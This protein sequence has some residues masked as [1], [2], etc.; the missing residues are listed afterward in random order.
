MLTS[1]FAFGVPLFLLI[2][3]I[4]FSIFRK[5][6]QIP[7]LG[8]VLFTIAGFLTAF[9]LQVIQQAITEM[10]NTNQSVLED[11]Y[12]YPLYLLVIPLAIGILLIILNAYRGYK[13]LKVIRLQ[14][15]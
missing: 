9:S 14:T 7:Y 3:Y 2:L 10:T 8:F 13:R 15:K 12:G 5:K 4:G 11:T 6:S 1:F